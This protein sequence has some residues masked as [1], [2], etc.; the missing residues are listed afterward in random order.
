MEKWKIIKNYPNYMVSNKGRVYS[1][2]T[3]K[4]LKF[5]NHT[6]GY[7]MVTLVSEDGVVYSDVLVHRLV[8]EAFLPK[9]YE[10]MVVNHKDEDRK[11]N[12][13]RN[14]EWVTNSENLR[15]TTSKTGKAHNYPI[16]K[17]GERYI[18][19]VPNGFRVVIIRSGFKRAVT[20]GTMPE[21]IQYRKGVLGA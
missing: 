8:A 15:Y 13:V 17:S 1:F 10:G 14:L 9:P 12:D 6:N 4:Y 20:F 18:H 5:R 7:A 16:G 11:N 19:K 21:A 2:K 3:D